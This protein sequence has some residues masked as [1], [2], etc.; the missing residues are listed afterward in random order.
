MNVVTYNSPSGETRLS[1]W[2]L[3]RS[4]WVCYVKPDTGNQNATRK[5]PCRFR[6]DWQKNLDALRSD[7]PLGNEEVAY[8]SR[9]G[10]DTPLKT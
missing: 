9:T 7:D 10:N 2:T 4:A 1:L 3:R 8:F 6:G 5:Q